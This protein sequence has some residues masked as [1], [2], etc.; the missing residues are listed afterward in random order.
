MENI[1][2]LQE[3]LVSLTKG[4]NLSGQTVSAAPGGLPTPCF[5]DVIE[6]VLKILTGG[7]WDELSERARNYLKWIS[8]KGECI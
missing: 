8:V 4:S 7:E 3:Y 5:P 6:K 2:E 1:E